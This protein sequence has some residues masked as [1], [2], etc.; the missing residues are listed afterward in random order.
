VVIAGRPNVG[1]SSLTN[2]IVGYERALVFDQPGT[3]RD[4]VWASTAIDGW[5][6]ELADTA[7]IRSGSGDIESQGIERA[8][9]QLAAADLVVLVT[10]ARGPCTEEDLALMAEWPEALLV[11]NKVD[12]CA[13]RASDSAIAT[14]A[15]TGEGVERLLEEIARRLMPDI[16]NEGDEERG[17]GVPFTVRQQQH[18]QAA[19]DALDERHTDK[20][21]AR[22]RQLIGSDENAADGSDAFAGVS[23]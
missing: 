11:A 20:A 14:S 10:D 8:R 19:A 13:G 1:K 2:R 22:L 3:T 17:V 6:V 18:L 4:V 23:D 21:I 16:A 12:L 9:A 5:P 15:K 7:G